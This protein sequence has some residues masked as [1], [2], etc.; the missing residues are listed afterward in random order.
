[1]TTD[2]ELLNRYATRRDE[3]AFA[4]LVRRHLDHV[5]S[6]ALRLV[7]GDMH[8]AEDVAQTVFTDLARK[9]GLLRGH[10]VLSGWLHTG[11]RFAAAKAVRSE[12]RRRQREQSAL[13][14]PTNSATEPDWEQVR[15][16][17][18]EAIGEL[19]EADRNALLLRYFE[20]KPLAQIGTALG[21]SENAARMRVDR[22]LDKLRAQLA[23]RGITS[24]VV[25]LG[26]ALAQNAVQTAPPALGARVASQAVIAG[27]AAGLGGPSWFSSLTR[28]GQLGLATALVLVVATVAVIMK[29]SRVAPEI[30]ATTGRDNIKAAVQ[31]EPRKAGLRDRT[32]TPN[33]GTSAQSGLEL[34]FVDDRTGL[35]I[36]NRTGSLR[37][38]E[39]G[40][41]LLVEKIVALEQG[42][43]LVPFDPSGGPDF[44]IYTHTEGHAD[45]RL[46]W[47][48]KR[49]DDIPQFYAIRLVRPA[50]IS[51]RVV[52]SSGN[53]VA[54]AEVGFNTEH[55]SGDHA[56]PESHEVDYVRAKTDGDG[57]WRINR[58]APEMVGRLFGSA[59][60]PDHA[61]S[62]MIYT[63]RQPELEQ[64][65]LDGSLVFH[66]KAG[67]TVRGRVVE[68]WGQPI[69]GAT[70]WVG[71]LRSSSRRETKSETDGTFRVAGCEPGDAVLSAQ[72][73][74]YAPTA[75]A[76]KLAPD[77]APAQLTLTAGKTLRLRVVDREGQPVAGAGVMLDSFPRAGRV[78]PVP[79]INFRRATDA[80]GRLVW[81]NAPDQELAFDVAARGFIR[82]NGVV[83]R[84]GDEEHLI[85]LPTA[86]TIA[87]TVTDLVTGEQIPRFRIG[88]GWPQPQ[89]DGSVQPRWSDLDRFWLSF[90]G[91]EFRHALEEAVIEGNPNPGYIFRFEAEGHSPFV[92]RAYQANEGEVRLE[93]QLKPAE[94]I[95]AVAY[96]PDGYAAG[97]AQVGLI[98]PGSNTR[99]VQGGFAGDLG[100]ALANIRQVDKDGRFV[101]P[102]DWSVGSV[103]VAHPDGYAQVT[104]EG[105]RKTRAIRLER[106]GG[107]EGVWR[108][109]GQ[110]VANGE[111]SVHWRTQRTNAPDLE[112][113]AFRTRADAN[114][115]FSFAKV[116]PGPFELLAR[117]LEPGSGLS[118]PSQMRIKLEVRAG[119][120]NQVEVGETDER[121]G[122]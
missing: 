30:S 80:E 22:A 79:Q 58:I 24:T 69:A 71:S 115:H 32:A 72:A 21:L 66:L 33:S 28:F 107:I 4:E 86:L 40:F 34:F 14:M 85:T 112:D 105:L 36:T 46:S 122:Q 31:A 8:L 9:A 92:T 88:I 103:A 41:S 12:Q 6:T 65:L 39:R 60:H 62:E 15:F 102:E 16:V 77:V 98:A 101:V 50:L 59:S 70:V 49:G 108:Q 87:G 52:D 47:Q 95:Y 94:D 120:T 56:S 81:I 78:T 3:A 13:A 113:Q 96:T 1:M 10:A 73:N 5:Y 20:K 26:T 17:L 110:P 38:W 48:P 68:S 35:A 116:P 93:V 82:V 18:D 57:R 118:A 90:I 111:L 27:G 43:C 54:G 99:L 64:Q 44:R 100:H 7:G 104:L 45:V 42:R 119:E 25:A 37:G 2:A 63:S 121:P 61:Q 67:V 91:G 84:P 74:G 19:G 89:P 29:P 75:V 117:Q 97:N 51:G 106:W 11:A 55:V 53:A 23:L 109:A 76:L 114:G 83:V